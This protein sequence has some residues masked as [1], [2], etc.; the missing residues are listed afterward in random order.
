M[1]L[2]LT[3]KILSLPASLECIT[4]DKLNIE[5]TDDQQSKLLRY[6]STELHQQ[7]LKQKDIDSEVK[8]AKLVLLCIREIPIKN[9]SAGR[10]VV[11]VALPLFNVEDIKQSYLEEIR[12]FSIFRLKT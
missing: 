8:L 7:G 11:D 12:E 4:I 6:Y 5:A 1:G 3:Q 10:M 2:I 9:N